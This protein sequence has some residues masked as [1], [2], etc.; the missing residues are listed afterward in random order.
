MGL[1][2]I[3]TDEDVFL[4]LRLLAGCVA[5][6]HLL[7]VRQLAQDPAVLPQGRPCTHVVSDASCNLHVDNLTVRQ[8]RPRSAISFHTG[9]PM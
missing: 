8:Y 5:N 7:P 6:Y 4:L 2:E 3:L 9:L 1:S